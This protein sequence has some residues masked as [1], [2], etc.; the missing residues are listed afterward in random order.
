MK[1]MNSAQPESSTLHT[2]VAA[3]VWE[4]G[5]ENWVA[6]LGTPLPPEIPTNKKK[7]IARIWILSVP[8]KTLM[9]EACSL[10]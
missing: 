2:T 5:T 10:A 3:T 6:L 9:L 4:Q 8:C 7:K 1:P